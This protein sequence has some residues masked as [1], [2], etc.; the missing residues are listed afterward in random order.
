MYFIFMYKSI[1]KVYESQTIPS[2][3]KCIR[4]KTCGYF[5]LQ[6][7]LGCLPRVLRN[8]RGNM[9]C[10]G[11]SPILSSDQWMHPSCPVIWPR[12]P[13]NE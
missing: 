10:C 8:C 12:A 4:L 7:L 13:R 3:N 1:N 9:N 5:K 6:I 2:F 11:Y